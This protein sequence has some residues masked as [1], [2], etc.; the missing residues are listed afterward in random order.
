MIQRFSLALVKTGW[1]K[2]FIFSED[3]YIWLLFIYMSLY[4]EFKLNEG[5]GLYTSDATINKAPP[6]TTCSLYRVMQ[7]KAFKNN[8]YLLFKGIALLLI[9]QEIRFLLNLKARHGNLFNLLGVNNLFGDQPE[10]SIFEF[11]WLFSRN[12]KVLLLLFTAHLLVLQPAQ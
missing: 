8:I 12:K 11:K 7:F 4:P 5:I 10:E 2:R 6:Q 1:G 3:C 9:P